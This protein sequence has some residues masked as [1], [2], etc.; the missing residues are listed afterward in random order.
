MEGDL[1]MTDKIL[2]LKLVKILEIP[3]ST[4]FIVEKGL[5]ELIG[6]LPT[7]IED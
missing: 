1:M 3:F 7:N 5:F 2:K 4:P 6:G